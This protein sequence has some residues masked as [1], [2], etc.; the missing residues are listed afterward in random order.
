MQDQSDHGACKEP[1]NPA[2]LDSH[3]VSFDVL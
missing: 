3:I 2:R 1:M